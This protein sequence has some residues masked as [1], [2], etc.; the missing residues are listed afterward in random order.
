MSEFPYVDIL[1]N[2]PVPYTSYKFDEAD[3]LNKI[4]ATNG[5]DFYQDIV[6][7]VNKMQDAHH[8][9]YPPFLRYFY[10]A[11]PYGIDSVAGSD[12]SRRF[13]FFN[14]YL[15]SGFRTNFSGLIIIKF[16]KLKL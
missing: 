3:E 12:G 5:L 8:R 10:F 7:I 13:K 16:I 11:L 15:S 9:F 4:N 1:R 6:R 14:N 2:P